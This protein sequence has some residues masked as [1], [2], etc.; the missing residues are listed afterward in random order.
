MSEFLTPYGY[1]ANFEFSKRWNFNK[2]NDKHF[3]QASNRSAVCRKYRAG[4]GGPEK[5]L[6]QRGFFL[7]APAKL[8]KIHRCV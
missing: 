8:P 7:T 3:S 6:E 4:T 1:D 5:M 2:D